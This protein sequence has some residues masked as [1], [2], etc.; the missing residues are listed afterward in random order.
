MNVS[1][2]R[3][4]PNFNVVPFSI[5]NVGKVTLWFAPNVGLVKFSMDGLDT[6]IVP[7][8]N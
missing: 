4:T 6:A 1:V 5:E 8:A 7:A 3:T 2:R